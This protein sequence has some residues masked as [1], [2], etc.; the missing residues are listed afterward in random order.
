MEINKKNEQP[1][2][3]DSQAS[4][5]SSISKL[6]DTKLKY[7]HTVSPAINALDELMRTMNKISLITFEDDLSDVEELL[8]NCVTSPHDRSRGGNESSSSSTVARKYLGACL[9]SPKP[10]VNT[11]ERDGAENRAQSEEIDLSLSQDAQK[12]LSPR[13][14]QEIADLFSDSEPEDPPRHKD[15]IYVSE[16]YFLLMASN[17]NRRKTLPE[18]PRSDSRDSAFSEFMGSDEE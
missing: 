13:K 12:P 10:F 11:Y 14:L 16:A 8:T 1:Q 3:D 18:R 9:S 7:Y 4:T 5:S 15:R 17:R 2:D 6:N